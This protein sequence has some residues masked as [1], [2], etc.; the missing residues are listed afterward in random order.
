MAK[1]PYEELR[2]RVWGPIYSSSGGGPL[3][4][5]GG[6]RLINSPPNYSRR[7]SPLLF[8][9]FYIVG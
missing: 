9:L 4:F 1:G 7:A 2:F 8:A 6:G 5:Y 3:L